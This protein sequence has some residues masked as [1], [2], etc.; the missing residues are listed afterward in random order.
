MFE[1]PFD[2]FIDYYYDLEDCEQLMAE[3]RMRGE[4][5][6]AEY[7]VSST[8]STAG[9]AKKLPPKSVDECLEGLSAIL[10]ECGG[11]LPVQ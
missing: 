2:D 6:H 5:E 4:S 7:V 3:E 9:R 1:H 8:G 10:K 11:R